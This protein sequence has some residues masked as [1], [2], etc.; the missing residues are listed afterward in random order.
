MRDCFCVFP[1]TSQVV[2]GS[3]QDGAINDIAVVFARRRQFK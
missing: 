2:A 3:A 1:A